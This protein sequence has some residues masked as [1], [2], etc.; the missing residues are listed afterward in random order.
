MLVPENCNLF[1]KNPWKVLEI[2]LSEAVPCTNP[3][4]ITANMYPKCG[5]KC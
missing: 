3:H 4:F 1:L 5:I 2:C